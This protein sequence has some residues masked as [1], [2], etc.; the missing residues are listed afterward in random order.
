MVF[1]RSF[2]MQ[3]TIWQSFLQPDLTD[4]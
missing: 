2:T 4:K 3:F 1:V